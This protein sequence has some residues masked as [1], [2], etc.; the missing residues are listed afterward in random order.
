MPSV[1]GPVTPAM[2]DEGFLAILDQL[3]YANEAQLE[4]WPASF[5]SDLPSMD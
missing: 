1:T 5:F 4:A 3:V 2:D